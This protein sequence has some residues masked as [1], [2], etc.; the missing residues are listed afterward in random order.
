MRN[1]GN[2]GL[3]CPDCYRSNIAEVREYN[4]RPRPV[5]HIG[6]GEVL[7]LC[8]TPMYG[9]ELETDKYPGDRNLHVGKIWPLSEG[10]KFFYAKRDGSLE[11]GIE[12]CFHPRTYKSWQESAEALKAMTKAVRTEGG[13]SW[14]TPTQSQPK[15]SCGIHIHRSNDDL[16]QLARSKLLVAMVK[17]EPVVLTLARRI[18]H[19]ANF[20]FK[21]YLGRVGETERMNLEEAIRYANHEDKAVMKKRLDTISQNQE[22][23]FYKAIEQ[24]GVKEKYCALNLA[25]TSTIEFRVFKG[26]LKVA[27]IYGYLAVVHHLCNWTLNA[28]SISR[29]VTGKPEALWGEF[30]TYAKSTGDKMLT[31]YLTATNC[32]EYLPHPKIS[33]KKGED[34]EEE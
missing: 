3:V 14:D 25:H 7:D 29:L 13:R 21:N 9:M 27:S 26:T 32:M 30:A 15:G 5:F 22:K 6:K 24:G 28:V 16:S 17:F 11:N 10:G 18:S 8:S 12:F 19:Y 23:L 1:N 31:S 20:D 4:Y 2:G 33:K 34:M